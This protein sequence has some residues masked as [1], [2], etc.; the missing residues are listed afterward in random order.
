MAEK[1]RSLFDRE[2]VSRA[3]IDSRQRHPERSEQ[4]ERSRRI[5]ESFAHLVRE[6]GTGSSLA[7]H[8]LV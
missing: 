4:R 8:R 6:A 1:T 7:C 2:I 3:L 5:S